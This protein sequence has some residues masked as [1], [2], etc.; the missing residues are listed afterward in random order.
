MLQVPHERQ[1]P[2]LPADVERA[3]LVS[4]HK[5]QT[6]TMLSDESDNEPQAVATSQQVVLILWCTQHRCLLICI[7]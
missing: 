4:Q 1:K 2:K 7:K 3:M 6:Y 5:P